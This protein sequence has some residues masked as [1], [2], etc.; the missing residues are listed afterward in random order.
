M[1]S[2]GGTTH[3]RGKRPPRPHS[4][5]RTRAWGALLLT[6]SLLPALAC[7]FAF[8]RWLPD[9]L[10]RYRD[11]AS[12]GPCAAGTSPREHEDCLR[13]VVFTVD[14]T[15]IKGG[16]GAVYRATLSGAPF[17]NGVLDFGDS[18]PLLSELEPGDR[19][20]GTVW[21]GEIMSVSR[22]G[23]LQASSDE[24]RDDPQMPAAL[25]TLAGLLAA[26][27]LTVGTA[28]LTRP[29]PPFPFPWRGWGKPMLIIL[30]VGCPVLGLVGVWW[31]IPWW[32]FPPVLVPL[33]GYTAWELHRYPR[34]RRWPAADS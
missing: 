30:C 34:R 9:D 20:T 32:L 11:Y 17:W 7:S 14:A 22:D 3:R 1:A 18:G 26:L 33:M 29:N 21:R 6:L 2:R 12:A 10:D 19:V 15:R 16:K 23:L 4:P 27:A 28:R 24:P 31:D 8:A 25:G 5:A 13:E